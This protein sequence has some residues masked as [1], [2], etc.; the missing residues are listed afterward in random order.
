M[1][2]RTELR[3]SVPP[4]AV[5]TVPAGYREE[6]RRLASVASGAELVERALRGD[7]A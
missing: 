2:A 3:E 4:H 6:G 7:P 5:D 1:S